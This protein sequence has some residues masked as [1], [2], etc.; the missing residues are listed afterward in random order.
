MKDFR[1]PLLLTLPVVLTACSP[2][3]EDE[4]RQWIIEQRANTRAGVT[5]LSEPKKFIPELYT[6]DGVM[7]P[8]DPLKLTRGSDSDTAHAAENAALLAPELARRKEPLEAFPLDTMAMVGSLNK[9]GIPTALLRVENLIYQVHVGNY[10]GQ[11]YG[12]VVQITENSIQLREIAQDAAG[13]WVERMA[14]LDLQEGKK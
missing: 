6:Q 4:L 7:D 5:P 14:S 13:D 2:G 9:T 11:N 3:G 8:F 10:L 12:K 1:I